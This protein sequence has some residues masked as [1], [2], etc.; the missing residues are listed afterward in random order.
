M[1]MFASSFTKVSSFSNVAFTYGFNYFKKH[2]Y[3]PLIGNSFLKFFK[4]KK[5][6]YL[7]K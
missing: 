5:F 3:K 2:F 7:S 1:D 4:Y 6:S